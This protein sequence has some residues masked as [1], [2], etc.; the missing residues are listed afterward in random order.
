[1]K[2]SDSTPLKIQLLAATKDEDIPILDD[3]VIEYTP[4]RFGPLVV[5]SVRF[6]R[7]V[8]GRPVAE[9]VYQYTNH[10]RFNAEAELKFDTLPEDPKP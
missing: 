4:S 5:S 7:R 10:Q 3:G 6:V 1:V 8:Q 2:Q 9:A